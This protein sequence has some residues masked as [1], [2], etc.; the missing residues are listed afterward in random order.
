LT[1]TDHR[2]KKLIKIA[3]NKAMA[4]TGKRLNA[5]M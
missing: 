1:P 3:N 2:T 4:K 5:L